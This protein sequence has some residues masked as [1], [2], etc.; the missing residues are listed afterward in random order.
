[1]HPTSNGA[2]ADNNGGNNSQVSRP[3]WVRL[4]KPGQQC[5]ITGL[6][7]SFLAKLVRE[8]KVDSIS[9]RERGAKK[10]VRLIKYDSLMAFIERTGRLNRDEA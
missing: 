3:E 5:N 6:G 1:M 2:T 9:L 10:G 8:G 7:R 4:P